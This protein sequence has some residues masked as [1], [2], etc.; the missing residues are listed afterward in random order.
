MNEEI[1]LFIKP[2]KTEMFRIKRKEI[3]L[4]YYFIE[5]TNKI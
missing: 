1:S 4:E 2:Y 3:L 5:N